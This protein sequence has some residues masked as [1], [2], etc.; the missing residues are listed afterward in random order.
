MNVSFE[1]HVGRIPV[2][3]IAVI[4]FE[5]VYCEVSAYVLK[6]GRGRY[7]IQLFDSAPAK[8]LRRKWPYKSQAANQQSP[9]RQYA[10]QRAR[11][12]EPETGTAGAALYRL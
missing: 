10:A 11:S 4:L 3:G 7:E 5:N 8:A 6:L 9:Y 2:K 1:I 12:G